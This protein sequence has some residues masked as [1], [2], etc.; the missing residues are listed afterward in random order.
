[1]EA[2]VPRREQYFYT[3]K[4]VGHTMDFYGGP[5]MANSVF[6]LKKTAPL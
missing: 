4:L 6:T 1:M 2:F 3:A 5:F